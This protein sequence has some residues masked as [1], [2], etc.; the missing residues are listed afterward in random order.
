MVSQYPETTLY[1]RDLDIVAVAP[2]GE[3]A[4]F[5]TIWYDDVT[6]TGY[7]PVGVVPEYHRRGLERQC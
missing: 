2:G 7:E 3:I 1:R 6:R 4:G 5:C